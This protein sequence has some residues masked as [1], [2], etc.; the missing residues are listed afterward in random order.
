MAITIAT[1]VRNAMDDA[2]TALTNGGS[3]QIRTGSKPSSPADAATGTLLATITLNTPAFGAATS[4][5][6]SLVTTSLNATAVAD[7]TAGWFRILSSGAAALMDGLVSA[8]GGGGDI[9]MTPAAVVTGTTCT[10]TS[11]T[12]TVPIGS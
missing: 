8:A 7:G 4:G 12:L 9:I 3:I 2:A 1:A 5:S 10:I 11:G 6:A